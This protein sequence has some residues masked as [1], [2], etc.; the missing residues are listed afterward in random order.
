MHQQLAQEETAHQEEV[1]ERIWYKDMNEKLERQLHS[2]NSVL[3]TLQEMVVENPTAHIAKDPTTRD[4]ENVHLDG[5][6]FEDAK[7]EQ[8]NCM[9]QELTL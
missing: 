4:E 7:M 2:F 3:S 1:Q 5:Y 6:R 9:D 8:K